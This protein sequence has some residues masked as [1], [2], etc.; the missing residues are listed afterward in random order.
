MFSGWHAR[1]AQLSLCS[2][3]CT[4][5]RPNFSSYIQI[6]V[7]SGQK[8]ASS[9]RCYVTLGF[10]IF[11]GL[12]NIGS[13]LPKTQNTNITPPKPAALHELRS[14]PPAFLHTQKSRLA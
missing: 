9:F 7:I 4:N 8:F 2:R 3:I 14:P 6:I 13:D 12:A 10:S 11:L 5:T 1:S